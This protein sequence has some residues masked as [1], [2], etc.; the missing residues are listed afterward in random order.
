MNK[1]KKIDLIKS[2]KYIIEND[3]KGSEE[4]K[5]VLR[6]IEVWGWN[7]ESE[8]YGMDEVGAFVYLFKFE[9]NDRPR[10]KMSELVGVEEPTEPKDVFTGEFLWNEVISNKDDLDDIATKLNQMAFDAYKTK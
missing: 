5:G 10:F 2:G 6:E 4:A 1:H 7:S 8:F 3:M 9:L